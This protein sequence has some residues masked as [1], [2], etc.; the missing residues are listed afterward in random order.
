MDLDC[1]T[2]AIYSVTDNGVFIGN[3][4]PPVNPPDHV[5]GRLCPLDNIASGLYSVGTFTLAP[6]PHTIVVRDLS[7]GSAEVGVMLSGEST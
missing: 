2:G 7:G 6:G 3:T 5:C 1:S 4:A